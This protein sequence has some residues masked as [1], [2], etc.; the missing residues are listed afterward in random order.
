MSG[1]QFLLFVILLLMKTIGQPQ[2]GECVINHIAE[3]FVLGGLFAAL[4]GLGDN[5]L[6]VFETQSLQLKI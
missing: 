3:F 6:L 2:A 5:W 1:N 4:C